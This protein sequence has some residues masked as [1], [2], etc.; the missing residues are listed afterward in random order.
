MNSNNPDAAD[1]SLPPTGTEASADHAA[2][3]QPAESGVLDTAS[4]VADLAD[5]AAAVFD[6]FG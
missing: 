3:Q 1:A 4:G 6:L 2:K 5:F